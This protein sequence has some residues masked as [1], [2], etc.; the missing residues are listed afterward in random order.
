MFRLQRLLA[1]ISSPAFNNPPFLVAGGRRFGVVGL[2]GGG[3]EREEI[4]P[5]KPW[6][7]KVF[8]LLRGALFS[9]W[10]V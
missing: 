2:R 9:P 4:A 3:Q 10:K 7:Q 5:G 1:A 6:R 8:E